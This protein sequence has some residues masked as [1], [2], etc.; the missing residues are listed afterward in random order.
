MAIF[1]TGRI[2]TAPLQVCLSGHLQRRAAVTLSNPVE[3]AQDTWET[4]QPPLQ[5]IFAGE[6]GDAQA[7]QYRHNPLPGRYQHDH[8]QNDQNPTE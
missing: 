5:I 3:G 4:N 1:A 8:A 2:V 6:I 7:D